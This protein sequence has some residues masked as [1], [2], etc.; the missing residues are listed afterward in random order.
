VYLKNKNMRHYFSNVIEKK[1]KRGEA[2]TEL[3]EVE[4]LGTL[5][6]PANPPTEIFSYLLLHLKGRGVLWLRVRGIVAQIPM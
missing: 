3:G 6:L 1:D 5:G 2:N 4:E